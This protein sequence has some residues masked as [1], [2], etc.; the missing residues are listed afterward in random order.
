[1]K[2][3]EAPLGLRALFMRR[4]HIGLGHLNVTDHSFSFAIQFKALPVEFVCNVTHH[5]VLDVD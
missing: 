2:R 4:C 5:Y 3:K 1:M